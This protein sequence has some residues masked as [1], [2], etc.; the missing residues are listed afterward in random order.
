[1]ATANLIGI[2]AGMGP[3]STTPFLEQVLDQCQLQY[4][5]KDDLD[6]PPLLIY[7]LPTPFYLDRPLDHELMEQT[8]S[9]GLR[10]LEAAGVRLVAMPCNTAHR[11]FDQ[12]QRSVGIPLLNIIT[13]TLAE[14][15][16]GPPRQ[17]VTLLATAST[18]SAG[19]YQAGLA[20]AGRQVVWEEQWQEPVNRLIRLIKDKGD[21]GQIE[22]EWRRL[23]KTIAAAG[24][25]AII[26][27]CTDLS[28]VA[29]YAGSPVPLI[30]SG[31]VL[32][33]AVVREYLKLRNNR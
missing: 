27:G 3:R 22:A 25:D 7:S 31:E 11:Y 33:K 16:A 10:Q 26:N 19:V 6:Y 32:A 9:A 15:A 29:K 28:V 1:M 21:S 17:R 24:V 30:D 13:E 8:I 5:A 20:A 12:L 14:L 23:T 18:Q 2:L 4:G